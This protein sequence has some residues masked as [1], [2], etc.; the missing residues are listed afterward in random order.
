MKREI[1]SISESGAVSVP[2]NVQMADFEIAHLLGVTYSMVR[3]KIKT[4]FKSRHFGDCSDGGTVR[5]NGVIVPDYFGLEMVVAVAMQVDS[6]EAE[7]FRKWALRRLT[8][9]SQPIY[10]N[11]S[12][13]QNKT[14]N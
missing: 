1:I 3:G 8:Q 12:N 13:T 11:I 9:Q 14:L 7:I 5:K 4:L 6:Y 2:S 10:I